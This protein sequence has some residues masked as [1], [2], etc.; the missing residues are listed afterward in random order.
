MLHP[1]PINNNNSLHLYSAFL[2]T[3][4]ALQRGG[5]SSTTRRGVTWNLRPSQYF[6]VFTF[7]YLGELVNYRQS[8]YSHSCLKPIHT[9]EPVLIKVTN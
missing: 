7:F 5:I 2:G 4:S 3:Q 9:T 6:Q 1:I 8:W